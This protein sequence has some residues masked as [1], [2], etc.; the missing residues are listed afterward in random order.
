MPLIGYARVSTEDQNLT[1]QREALTAA[2]C[3][4]IYEEKASGGSR[5]RP[6]LA[7]ALYNIKADDT[8]VVTK[9]DRLARS[10]AHLLEI[11]SRLTAVGASFKSLADPIDTTGPSGRLVLQ[12]LGAVAEFERALIRERTVTGLKHAKS[13][14]RVGGNPGLR[15]G[16]PAAIAKVQATRRQSR[17]VSLNDSANIWLPVVY[18]LRPDTAW[19]VVLVEVN[20]AL[21][22][23]RERFTK[24]RLLRSLKLFIEEGLADPKVLGR[25]V[26]RRNRKADTKRLAAIQ[27]AAAIYAGQPK[28]TL[29]ELGAE[30][31]RL[32]HVPPRGGE[33]WGVSSIK[34]L[35]DQ[36]RGMGLI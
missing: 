11:I 24:E 12:M 17:L 28:I 16:D 27:T 32:R 23:N 8:L 1:G 13:Q 29:G 35:V 6:Q 9:I 14:G 21:G 30:L 5:A 15:N 22:P 25:A 18:R 4:I 33:K 10:L 34:A 36:A 2:G 26:H 31:A 19:E 7:Q 3:T 20:K